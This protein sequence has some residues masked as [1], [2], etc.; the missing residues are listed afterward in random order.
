MNWMTGMAACIPTGILHAASDVYLIVPKTVQAAMIAPTYHSV[1][2]M[3]V[4]FPRCWGWAS[5]VMSSGAEP[6]LTFDLDE[7]VSFLQW[8]GLTGLPESH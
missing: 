8:A 7:L 4:S 1:L 5:S 3:V 2:Y 6:W